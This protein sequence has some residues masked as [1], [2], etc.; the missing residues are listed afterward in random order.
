MKR[1]FTGDDR[2]DPVKVMRIRNEVRFNGEAFF[3]K[4]ARLLWSFMKAVIGKY[5]FLS[6]CLF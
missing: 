5:F 2:I 3:P 4:A 6:G 1:R